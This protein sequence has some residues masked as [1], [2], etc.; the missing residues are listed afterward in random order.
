MTHTTEGKQMTDKLI[1]RAKAALGNATPGPWRWEVSLHSKKVELCG[2]GGELTVMDFVRWGMNGAAA[3]FWSWTGKPRIG[4]PKRTDEI[5]V[6]VAGREHHSRWFRAIDD[7]N[8]ELIALAPDL[9][10]ALIREREAAEQLAEHAE[11][12]L[13]MMDDVIKGSGKGD[14]AIKPDGSMS[15]IGGWKALAAYR[16]ATKETDDGK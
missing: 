15:V 3:R 12:M 4:T 1:E 11:A 9:A 8:A 13:R 7:P 2:S 6:P 14:M 5:A 16:K 10:R